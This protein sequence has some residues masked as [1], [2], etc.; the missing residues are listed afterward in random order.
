[1][2]VRYP[3]FTVFPLLLLSS[4]FAYP[5][6][7]WDRLEFRSIGP[8][9][10]GGRTADVEGIPGNPNVVYAATGMGGL[11]RTINGGTTWTPLFE[12]QNTF[13]IGDIA[14]DPRNPE[15]IWLGAGESNVRNSVSFGDGVYKST[16]GGKTWKHMGLA[17]CERISRIVINPLNPDIVYVGA[18]GHI[19]GPHSERGVF[20]T[21]DGGKTW[22]K[23]LYIDDKHGVADL[24]ID[25]SNPNIVFAAMWFFERKPWTHH[26]GSEQSGLFRSI[27]GGGT[28]Q[29]VKGLPKL[30]GRIGVKVAPSNPKIVYVAAESNEGTLFRSTDNGETF[31]MV[32]KTRDLVGRGFYYAD[33]RVDPTDENRVYAIAGSLYVSID[34]AKSFRRISGNTHSDYHSLWIDPKDPRRMWQGQDG[35]IAVSYDRGETWESILNIPLGQFYQLHADNRQPFYYLTGGLQDNGTWTGPSRTREP[36][37]ILN[38][39]WRMVSFGDGFHVIN[40]PDEPDIFLTES[41]GGSLLRMDLST[42]EQQAVSPQPRSNAGGSAGEMK[43]RFNWNTPIVLSPH[44]KNIVYF[45]GNVLF[46]S[47]NFGL[48]W[49]QISPDLTTNDPAKQK[50]AGGPIWYDNSTAEN[51]STIITVAESPRRPG[52]IWTG[53][54]DG[55]LNRTI[56][57]GETWTNLTGNVTGLPRFAQVSRIEASRSGPDVAYVSF[58]HH[59]FD[60][61]SPYIYKTTDGGKT[62]QKLVSGLPDKAYV[63]VIREDPRNPQLLYAGTELGLFL[64]WNGGQSWQRFGLKNLPH[65]PVHEILVHPRENDLILAT[66]GR[67]IWIFDDAS[68]IQQMS[69]EVEKSPAWLFDMRPALRF[70]TRFT[71]YGIGSKQFAGP[72]PPYGAL[73]TYFLREKG[74][75]KIQILDSKGAVIRELA[76][77]PQEAGMN[78]INWD[79]RAE[80]PHL[81]RAPSPASDDEGF[82]GPPRGPQVLPGTYTV[83]LTAG[84]RTFDR[85]VEVK[86]DPTLK[87]APS[88]LATQY[89]YALKLR[90]LFS[91]ANDTLKRL[92]SLK[93]HLQ[94][95]ET[96]LPENQKPAVKDAIKEV[97]QAIGRIA[98]PPDAFRLEV[99]P[100]VA[101]QIQSLFFQIDGVNAGPTQPQRDYTAEL[102][103]ALGDRLKDLDPLFATKAPRWLEEFHRSD[104]P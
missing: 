54:D 45:S 69:A 58:E 99:G 9:I 104:K 33:L 31:Q 78:R 98:R 66:H 103:K 8:A 24:D 19:F 59:M 39:D 21:T 94:H 44:D 55:Q 10:M 30:I 16:D 91:R 90:D 28:W 86:L 83:R 11:W 35:G 18:L 53:S 34:G 63:H 57:A 17:N 12:R 87:V 14:L 67:S 37:G 23:T 25:P 13:S 49:R 7:S 82:Q 2:P 42:R 71:R 64:S 26:S 76:K 92:D 102:E 50:S 75:V 88:D 89:E 62:W 51:H 4:S 68:A 32:N 100:G 77:P 95:Y 15:V 1:M 61:F 40:H 93:Q 74:P 41:Q 65:V 38:D 97:D 52:T 56:D 72:N 70:T 3:H 43:F 20:R 47:T 5:Q 29:K 6:V 84:G 60:D 22:D 48:N 46:K 101:E 80:P 36:A 73:I 81:R 27:D 79:L 96:R 85:K